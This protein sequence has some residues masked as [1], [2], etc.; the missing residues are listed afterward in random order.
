MRSALKISELVAFIVMTVSWGIGGML[1]WR[2]IK[3]IR[4]IGW[5]NFLKPWS[6]LPPDVRKNLKMLWIYL[7]FIMVGAFFIYFCEHIIRL[8]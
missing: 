8:T 7:S 5:E 6:A 2:I 1:V 4:Q 3:Q